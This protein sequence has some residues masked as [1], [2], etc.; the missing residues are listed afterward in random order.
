VQIASSTVNTNGYLAKAYPLA[1]L[2]SSQPGGRKYANFHF[3][4]GQLGVFLQVASTPQHRGAM[5]AALL[6]T[7]SW[8]GLSTGVIT[9]SQLIQAGGLVISFTGDSTHELKAPIINPYGMVDLSVNDVISGTDSGPF[10]V[11]AMLAPLSHCSLTTAP[12]ITL[13]LRAWVDKPM[14]GVPADLYAY[15]IT[16]SEGVI[17]RPLGLVSDVFG[18]VADAVPALSWVATPISIIASIG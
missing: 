15:A 10:L 17:S 2:L 18:Y 1:S 9:A 3:M 11:T 5:V 8:R 16:S 6:P 7:W 13:T 14:L 4:S 12:T